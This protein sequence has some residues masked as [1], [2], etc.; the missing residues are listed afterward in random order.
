MGLGLFFI[1]VMLHNIEN[2][3]KH[4]SEGLHARDVE[5]HLGVKEGKWSV[6]CL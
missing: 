4:I 5:M 2:L 1:F 3:V 6:R